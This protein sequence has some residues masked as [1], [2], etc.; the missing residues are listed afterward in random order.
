LIFYGCIKAP[1]KA[2]PGKR[3][4]LD[5]KSKFNGPSMHLLPGIGG[6]LSWEFAV[7]MVVGISENPP[8]LT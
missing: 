1:D 3:L 8:S 6:Q 7:G 5:E 2:K 4:E